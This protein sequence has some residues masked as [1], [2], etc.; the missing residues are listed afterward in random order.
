LEGFDGYQWQFSHIQL[1]IH[2]I[3]H[4]DPLHDICSVLPGSD[5]T[6]GS[7]ILENLLPSSIG[8]LRGCGLNLRA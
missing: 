5:Y 8:V 4:S 3:R 7:N 2:F 1:N 6:L